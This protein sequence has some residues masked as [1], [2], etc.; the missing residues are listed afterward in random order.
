M[1]A[2]GLLCRLAAADVPKTSAHDLPQLA[3]F[4][5]RTLLSRNASSSPAICALSRAY[6]AALANSR[7]SYATSTRATEPTP[8][9]KKAVKKAAAAKKKAPA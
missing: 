1:L 6:N 3:R 2:R 7:R 5:Q 4:L 8:T 9:V